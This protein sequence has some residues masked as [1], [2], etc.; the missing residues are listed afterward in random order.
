MLKLQFYAGQQILEY[1][2]ARY[3]RTNCAW[4]GSVV[5]WEVLY[6]HSH[7]KGIVY[8]T[9][10]LWTLLSEIETIFGRL[11]LYICR[12]LSSPKDLGRCSAGWILY[13]WQSCFNLEFL[14]MEEKESKE[15]KR[16]LF[17]QSFKSICWVI[18][19][20]EGEFGGRDWRTATR[21]AGLPKGYFC[22]VWWN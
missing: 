1:V 18:G 16:S 12:H 3:T 13:T 10:E 14:I 11:P 7:W 2:S 20:V 22:A 9:L 19:I 6:R 17:A 5:T 21:L 8:N 4:C 15:E